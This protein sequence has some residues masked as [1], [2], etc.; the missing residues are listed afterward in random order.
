MGYLTPLPVKVLTFI[1][2]YKFIIILWLRIWHIWVS[3]IIFLCYSFLLSLECLLIQGLYYY[4][5]ALSL[6]APNEALTELVSQWPHL[7]FFDKTHDS[8]ELF[9]SLGC[10]SKF[11]VVIHMFSNQLPCSFIYNW[12]DSDKSESTGTSGQTF[13]CFHKLTKT[14][15]FKQ[16]GRQWR[17]HQFFGSGI[18][19]I[20]LCSNQCI[21]NGSIY[22]CGL[23]I[24]IAMKLQQLLWY[25][26]YLFA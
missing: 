17:Q 18:L 15:I 4:L 19:L 24:G 22:V 2:S 5:S 7:S 10:W 11:Q 26:S 9:I 14:L 12:R 20:N 1:I 21:L 3:K 13:E 6:E 23:F 8:C 25:I 16:K